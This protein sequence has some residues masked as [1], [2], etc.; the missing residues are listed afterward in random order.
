MKNIVIIG[1]GI[2]GL[3]AAY[4]ASRA[5]ETPVKITLL[6]RADYWGGKLVTERIP[7][8]K[9]QF[10]IEGGPDTFVVT[11]PWAVNL[12]KELD[13]ADRLKGTNSVTKKTY[14]LK[15]G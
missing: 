8:E 15:R 11:K 5:S 6:E 10:V 2:A 7:G 14:I 3:S 4:Y 13:I 9:G 1:G 12:C